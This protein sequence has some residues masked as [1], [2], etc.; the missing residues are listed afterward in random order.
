MKPPDPQPAFAVRD[1][2]AGRE[3][4]ILASVFASI[5]VGVMLTDL[6]HRTLAVNRRFCELFLVDGSQVVNLDVE[7]V[8][9]AV[10]SRIVDLEGWEANLAEIYAVPEASQVDQLTL[11]GPPC[12]L[13]RETHPVFNADGE[14]TGR[15]WTFVDQT[16]Q[17]R[18]EAR[19][20]LLHQMSTLFDPD[21][22]F[23]YTGLVRAISAFYDSTCV[24]SIRNGEIMEFHAISSPVPGV[25]EMTQNV[26]SESY[27]QFCLDQNGPTLI[28]DARL[29]PTHAAILPARVGMTRYMGVPILMNRGETRGTLCILDHRSEEILT[30]ED[31]RLMQLVAM[32]LTAELERESQLK[33][34]QR[35]LEDVQSQLVQSEKL[36]ATGA[37]A[38]TIAHD[39]RNIVSAMR[40]DWEGTAP[41]QILDHLDRFSVLCHRLLSYSHPKTLEVSSVGLAVVLHRV[42][43]LFAR[44]AE[45]ASVRLDAAEVDPEL[46]ILAAEDRLESLFANLAMNAIQSMSGGGTL[47]VSAVRL[48]PGLVQVCFAD[49]GPGF[50][51]NIA[52]RLRRPFRSERAGGFGLGLYSCGQIMRE[53]DGRIALLN[54]EPHGAVVELEFREG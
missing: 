16:L 26:L 53:V 37:L 10:R 40:L 6:D 31:L 47:R 7:E 15:I 13:H 51:T 2:L 14:V 50:P 22:R 9:E 5:D 32:R 43:E 25:E 33:H 30:G 44:H 11:T 21:P 45:L 52:E 17:A 29:D 3:P 39:V 24:L 34:L 36:A 49:S 19:D 42:L 18:R 54:G 41:P 48:R 4:E 23:V 46:R 20:A 1:I 38:A 27:C 28:Q 12:V 8:R 35:N